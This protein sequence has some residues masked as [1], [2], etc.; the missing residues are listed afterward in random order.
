M[1]K[2]NEVMPLLEPMVVGECTGELS[3]N[4][5]FENGSNLPTPE[6]IHQRTNAHW[7]GQG[8]EYW[9]TILRTNITWNVVT[10]PKTL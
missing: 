10:D 2:D 9:S 8:T 6:H 7:L 5:N 4:E 1:S 3:S